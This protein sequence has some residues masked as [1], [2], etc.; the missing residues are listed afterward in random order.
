MPADLSVY[1]AISNLSTLIGDIERST[2]EVVTT[3]AL[4]YGKYETDMH[5]LRSENEKLKRFTSEHSKRA[6]DLER[7]L[8]KVRDEYYNLKATCAAQ[9]SAL[10]EAQTKTDATTAEQDGLGKATQDAD[11]QH[12]LLR[13]NMQ[14]LTKDYDELK[15]ENEG[16]L[17]QNEG[18]RVQR[19]KHRTSAEEHARKAE[20][21]T[22]VLWLVRGDYYSQKDAAKQ[23]QSKVT[24]LTSRVGELVQEV[25]QVLQAK[26]DV[27][28]ELALAKAECEKL[29]A[30]EKDRAAEVVRLSK[31][32]STLR[33]EHEQLKRAWTL[34]IVGTSG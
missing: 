24:E 30:R 29:K 4:R 23:A 17:A 22:R 10:K 7:T 5:A 1:I 28:N 11:Q 31:E 19:D 12:E 27:A 32:N 16:L 18:L 34:S 21:V 20:E 9:A 13:Q 6:D 15:K 8:W 2:E 25:S 33:D 3:A 14:T 26:A